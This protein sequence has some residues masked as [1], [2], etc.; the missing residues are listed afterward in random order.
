MKSIDIVL[1]QDGSL[2]LIR[3]SAPPQSTVAEFRQ[4]LLEAEIFAGPEVMLFR[5]EQEESIPDAELL[6]LTKPDHGLH[7]ARCRRVAVTVH[8]NQKSHEFKLPPSARVRRVRR[9]AIE[10][11]KIP[12]ADAAPLVLQVTGTTEPLDPDTKIGS[13]VGRGTCS[14][15]L[16]LVPDSRIQG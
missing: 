15:A 13:L 10:A 6:D 5:D 9:L 2:E 1:T 11:F 8:Y 16:D 7:V 14:V 12:A 3:V 4:R